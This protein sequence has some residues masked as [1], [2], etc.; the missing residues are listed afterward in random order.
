M[1]YQTV[2]KTQNY[3]RAAADNGF[4]VRAMPEMNRLSLLKNSD[5]P[6]VL[7]FLNERPV[8]TVVL[9]SF[10]QDNGLEGAENRGRFYAYRNRDGRLEG[11]ALI[12]H[13]TLVEARSSEALAA[14]AAAARQSETPIHILMSDGRTIENFWNDYAEAG[15]KPRL[16]CTELLFEL[17]FPF[18]K[19]ECARE[20]RAARADELDQIAEAHAEVAFIESGVDPLVKDRAGFLKRCLNRIEKKRTF[21]VFENGKLIFKADIAAQTA[22]VIYLEGIYV[23]PERRGQG[24]ASGCLSKL[25]L[26]L[27]ESAEHICLLSNVEFKGAHRSFLKAGF[28]NTD[29]STTIFV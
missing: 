3:N 10:I 22:D 21:V 25:G 5:A 19:Q 16:S 1:K 26:E 9:A 13:A 28:K 29:S 11:V 12:G 15:Q 23:A 4:F 7:E 6:S 24:V 27:L 2:A 14:F 8:K 20:I 17:N 18:L